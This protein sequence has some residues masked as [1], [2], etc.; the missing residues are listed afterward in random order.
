MTRI[1]CCVIDVEAAVSAHPILEIRRGQVFFETTFGHNFRSLIIAGAR[2]KAFPAVLDSSRKPATLRITVPASRHH[3]ILRI[4]LLRC[5][6]P[7]SSPPS[8]FVTTIG[9]VL[10]GLAILCR[11]VDHDLI[12][13]GL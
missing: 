5:F 10:N 2:F 7:V 13:S 4:R 11:N 3:Q 6:R 9:V 8:A 12:L 1:C